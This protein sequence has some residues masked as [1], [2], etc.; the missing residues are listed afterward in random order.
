MMDK[1]M[2][3]LISTAS[4]LRHCSVKS[5]STSMTGKSQNLCMSLVIS[6]LPIDQG[7]ASVLFKLSKTLVL[8]F[9]SE[10]A[11][12]TM[13]F[14]SVSHLV[15]IED[16]LRIMSIWTSVSCLITM[17][18]VKSN[19]EASRLIDFLTKLRMAQKHLTIVKPSSDIRYL[20]NKTINFNV[21]VNHLGPGANDSTY[22]SIQ[23]TTLCLL[24]MKK[25]KELFYAQHWGRLMLFCTIDRVQRNYKILTA[26]S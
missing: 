14:S 22:H 20:Q 11:R 12:S 10:G 26:K 16:D 25:V 15:A 5:E 17:A 19:A 24:Q 23:F 8:T 18:K 13:R 21:M 6:L 2:L 4:I 9:L 3:C 1:V 7:N